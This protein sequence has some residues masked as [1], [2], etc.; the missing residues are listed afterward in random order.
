MLDL[1]TTNVDHVVQLLQDMLEL[2]LLEDQGLNTGSQSV[3]KIL[4]RAVG[5]VRAQADAMSVSLVVSARAGQ[6]VTDGDLTSRALALMLS[7][8]IRRA[9]ADTEVTAAAAAEG[10]EFR[11]TISDS[12]AAVPRERLARYF[13]VAGVSSGDATRGERRE[14]ERSQLGLTIARSI[15]ELLSGAVEVRENERGGIS[16]SLILPRHGFPDAVETPVETEQA[17]S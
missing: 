7:H 5:Q 12:G 16:M 14:Y 6:L 9:P 2:T 15:A 13:E 3:Q 8:C 4:E 1:V 10:D 11:F 17:D